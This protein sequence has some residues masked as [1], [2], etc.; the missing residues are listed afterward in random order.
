MRIGKDRESKE[1]D[2]LIRQPDPRGPFEGVKG[3]Q[4]L[5]SKGKKEI[6]ATNIVTNNL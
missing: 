6:R 4:A 1:T 5:L 2:A 3:E